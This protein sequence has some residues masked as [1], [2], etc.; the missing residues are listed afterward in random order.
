[1]GQKIR[2][3]LTDDVP[4]P[5]CGAK[6]GQACEVPARKDPEVPGRNKGRTQEVRW[7][8]HARKPAA[9]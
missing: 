4:C 7:L 2:E 9:A 6:P 3:Y 1:M 8:H 5:T